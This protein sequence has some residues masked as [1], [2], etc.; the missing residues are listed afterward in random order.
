MR[1]II[2]F[3]K[4]NTPVPVK[5]QSFI[6]YYIHKCLG[7]DNKYHNAKNDY[8]VSTLYAGKLNDDKKTLSFENGGYIVVTSLN[9]EFI[10]TLVSGVM[11]NKQLNWGME[12]ERFDFI[13]EKFY[14]GWNHF[15]TLSPFIIKKNTD[16]KNYDFAVLT[17]DDFVS[18]VKNH[19][20][21][22][23]RA[24]YKN[25]NLDD[26]DV[27]IVDH[28]SHKVK[29]LW[30]R[31]CVNQANQCQVSFFCSANVAEK[32]YNLG[33]GQSTG[34]GFGTIYKTENHKKYR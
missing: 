25:I 15:A 31:N 6:N 11:A 24:I 4:N 5:N 30:L 3:T 28:P 10:N 8:A 22:K 32:I 1:I 29:P 9:D 20:V 34:A 16:K 23:L 17:D 13:K 33:I 21:N 18:V 2:R 19:T 27:K 7:K 12:F 26:F 14:N